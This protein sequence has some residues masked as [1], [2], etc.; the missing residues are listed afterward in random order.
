MPSNHQSL[1]INLPT[2]VIIVAGGSGSRMQSAVPK[3]FLLLS[4]KPVLM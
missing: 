1:T 2:Y 4:G 3:Q